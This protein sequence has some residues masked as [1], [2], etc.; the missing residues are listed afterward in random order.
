MS[1]PDKKK[2]R[3]LQKRS[4]ALRYLLLFQLWRKRKHVS[5]NVYLEVVNSLSVS[6]QYGYYVIK[7]NRDSE[8]LTIKVPEHDFS[9]Y[10]QAPKSE[11]SRNAI[12]EERK[13]KRLAQKITLELL[14]IQNDEGAGDAPNAEPID[15]YAF[16]SF[17]S[18]W[19]SLLILLL[20]SGIEYWLVFLLIGI[21]ISLEVLGRKGKCL[22]ASL[23]LL[24]PFVSFPWIG[25]IGG[26]FYGLLQFLDPDPFYRKY[27]VLVSFFTVFISLAFVFSSN[28][29]VRLAPDLIL[30][31]LV[32]VI[33]AGYKAMLINNFRSMPLV[34][35]LL[36]P[37]FYLD[38][39]LQTGWCVVGLSF[40]GL[41]VILKGH[42][43]WPINLLFE[44]VKR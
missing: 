22:S 31:C 10:Q 32:S 28:E 33:I 29:T 40:L 16:M 19:L 21:I 9:F 23:F 44:Y 8:F 13:N 34:F 27:R 41:G 14:G 30:I 18:S 38:G 26:A 37:A 5:L 12:I 11:D 36:G 6:K 4:K 7:W 25:F 3:V 15:R 35:P 2:S 39:Y 17:I 42:A 24:F 43:L 1:K 20:I